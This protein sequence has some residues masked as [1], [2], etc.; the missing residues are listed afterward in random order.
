M[1]NRL[2]ALTL[3]AAALVW[4]V[5]VEAMAQSYQGYRSYGS[6]RT[7]TPEAVL[8]AQAA[9]RAAYRQCLRDNFR[10]DLRN[11]AVNAGSQIVGRLAN[12][13]IGGR[14][15]GYYGGGYSGSY[16]NSYR[17]E[18]IS[19]A[20]YQDMLSA[21]AANFSSCETRISTRIRRGGDYAEEPVADRRCVSRQ[22]PS[23]WQA[24]FAPTSAS[25]VRPYPRDT[26]SAADTSDA[27]LPDRW[28]DDE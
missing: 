14:S 15:L 1:S 12:E 6:E 26:D 20:V 4:F 16:T 9:A 24:E 11:R 18:G 23:D 2:F 28:S 5:P 8:E 7:H 10:D 22:S 25:Q 21:Q 27:A 13:L 3:T 17:C 19:R